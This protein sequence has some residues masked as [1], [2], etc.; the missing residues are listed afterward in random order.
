MTESNNPTDFFGF[1]DD[2]EKIRSSIYG[3]LDDYT[4]NNGHLPEYFNNS[5]KKSPFFEF[6][7]FQHEPYIH[8]LSKLSRPDYSESDFELLL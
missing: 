3:S 1:C 4:F 8:D 2:E 6:D 5:M 7:L